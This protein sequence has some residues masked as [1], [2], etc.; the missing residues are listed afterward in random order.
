MAEAK[1]GGFNEDDTKRMDKVR[2]EQKKEA[3][4]A[5]KKAK[6][7]REKEREAAVEHGSILDEDM[8]KRLDED[9]KKEKERLAKEEEAA[10]KGADARQAQQAGAADDK[11]AHAKK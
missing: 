2:A 9:D 7:D 5:E 1:P 11:A 4:E 3:D 8:A 10:R 6:D